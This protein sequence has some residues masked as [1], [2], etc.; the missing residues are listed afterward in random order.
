MTH[1]PPGATPLSRGDLET[2]WAVLM[3]G[4]TVRA[5]GG[6]L[7]LTSPSSAAF[8][9]A[10]ARAAGLVDWEYAK[11]AT[12]HPLYQVVWLPPQDVAD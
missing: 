4:N 10:R 5:V 6:L 1:L 9:L 2:L 3:G 7:G 12:I 11:A 8:R